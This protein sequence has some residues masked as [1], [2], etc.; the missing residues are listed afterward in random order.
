MMTAFFFCFKDQSEL[1]ESYE[2]YYWKWKVHLSISAILHSIAESETYLSA[3][4]G[5]IYNWEK[6]FTI[7]IL[8]VLIILIFAPQLF[9]CF[10]SSGISFLHHHVLWHILTSQYDQNKCGA[11]RTRKCMSTNL[12]VKVNYYYICFIP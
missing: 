10:A 8:R 2:R 9:L 12:I 5:I 3:I 4:I 7:A 1:G 6:I 11:I